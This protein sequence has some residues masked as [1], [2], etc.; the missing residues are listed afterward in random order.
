M[1]LVLEIQ[2]KDC[3]NK[4]SGA[5]AWVNVNTHED[6]HMIITEKWKQRVLRY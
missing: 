3:G 4:Y 2:S 6:A 1:F 5:Q